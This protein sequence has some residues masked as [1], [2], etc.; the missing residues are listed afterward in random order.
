MKTRIRPALLSLFV[1]YAAGC[2]GLGQREAELYE[3]GRVALKAKDW[4]QAADLLTFVIEAKP[5]YAPA[6]IFRGRARFELGKYAEAS[7][8][9]EAGERIGGLTD[10]EHFTAVLFR[11]RC[12]VEEGRITFP[13]G[14]L[15]KE[16]ASPEERRKARDFFLKANTLVLDALSLRPNNYDA[17]L[18]RGYC[19]FRLENF[20]KAIDT[21]K[22]CEGFDPT[23]WE[24]RFF[25][26]LSWEG[27]YKVNSQ[28]L[29]SY[30][31]ILGSGPRPELAPVYEYL[32]VIRSDVAPEIAQ[33]IYTSVKDFAAKV[34][35]HSPRI[36]RFLAEMKASQDSEE[37][38]A[39]LR[40]TVD[41]VHRLV[42]SERFREAVNAIENCLKEVGENQ[43][44]SRLLRETEESWSL[45]LE[46][47]TEALISSAEKE[48]L[49]SALSNYTLA[50]KLTSK[51]DRLVVLQQKINAVQLALTR[52]ETSRKIQQTYDLLKQNKYQEVLDQLASTS[53]D[54]LSE[55]DRDLY[56]YLR[57][58]SSYRLGQWT[59]AAKAFSAMG[60]RNFEGLEALQGIA[61]V[62][63][64]QEVA[65][66]S[67]LTNIPAESRNDEVNRILGQHFGER[68]EHQKA[69]GY[70][71][72]IK[73]PAPADL[74]AHLKSRKE[75]GME[76]YK[77]ADY[78]HAIEE[79]SV[80]RQILQVQLHQKGIDVYLYLGNA[81]FRLEDLEKAKKTYQDLSETDLTLAERQQCRDL[82]LYRSQIHLREKSSDLAFKDISEFVRL[83]GQVP[84]D[85]AGTYGRLVATY[86]DFMPLEKVQYWNYISNARD[87]NYSLFVKDE[88]NGEYRIERRETGKRSEE[89][90]SR[91]GIYLTKKVGEALMKLPLNLSPA[92]EALPVVEYQSQG[93]ECTAEVVAIQQT[94]E[95]Q[96]GRKFTDCLKVR[97][98]R[99]SQKAADGKIHSTKYIFYLA[100]GV[101]EVRQE[102]YRDD[103]KVSEIV[104][105]DFAYKA[106]GEVGN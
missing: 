88:T 28:S 53:V 31:A 19:L 37:R 91:S 1:V 85:Y 20:R 57:G 92:E 40:A 39:K 100:P 46:A 6:Y 84:A 32:T 26:A 67:K 93:Q 42:E 81:Y 79:L 5:R 58:V 52:Q 14:E 75:L 83:G 104:L 16:T 78:P 45:L 64:G 63:S 60:Q 25:S 90:W 62:R 33:R 48:K 96:A 86:A 66:V 47:R 15:R 95:G 82:F 61:L 101:G 3:K 7:K 74:E 103:T 21:F 99:R 35:G 106:S 18:W 80:A 10:D 36:D 51:V 12:I 44:I 69:A 56:H 24:H 38:Q 77:R 89:K 102:V 30:F 54:G 23:R 22:V 11:A 94:V 97:V 59:S 8:D 29:E 73:S 68:G 9:F 71:A 49:E 55:R 50:R 43:E 34:P 70:L 17:N 87:Y 105:S 76:Y 13:E 98:L 27:I 65:G 4:A 41:E 72:A 2:G